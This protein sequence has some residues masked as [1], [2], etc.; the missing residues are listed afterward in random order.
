MYVSRPSNIVVFCL[1]IEYIIWLYDKVTQRGCLISKS[2]LSCFLKH[3]S[4]IVAKLVLLVW[5]WQVCC[6]FQSRIPLSL[7]F[8]HLNSMHVLFF[9][10][11]ST[12]FHNSF[13]MFSCFAGFFTSTSTQTSPAWG[14]KVTVS[15]SHV[16]VIQAGKALKGVTARQNCRDVLTSTPSTL[17]LWLTPRKW[18]L[19]AAHRPWK[20]NMTADA[21]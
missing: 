3:D 6:W 13:I 15:N 18:Q 2:K 19:E 16:E 5:N 17:G 11:S 20:C 14:P 12:P 9:T 4:P 7:T 10:V 8:S 1:Q 21:M